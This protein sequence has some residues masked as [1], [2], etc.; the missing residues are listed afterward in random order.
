MPATK[1]WKKLT[2]RLLNISF[3]IP[4]GS[5]LNSMKYVDH[6]VEDVAV[7]AGSIIFSAMRCCDVETSVMGRYADR[8]YELVTFALLVPSASNRTSALLAL[9]V[10]TFMV[11]LALSVQSSILNM[12]PP[13]TLAEKL[14]VKLNSQ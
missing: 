1:R 7:P 3:F 9:D 2:K 10:L 6:H 5:V 12:N 13:D 8:L 4:Q 14:S 11:R